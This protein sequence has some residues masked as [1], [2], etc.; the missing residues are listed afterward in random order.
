MKYKIDFVMRAPD[1]DQEHAV[2]RGYFVTASA[3]DLVVK[4]LRAVYSLPDC[5]VVV[6][7]FERVD[8]DS[9]SIAMTISDEVPE[10]VYLAVQIIVDHCKDRGLREVYGEE[11]PTDKK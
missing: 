2:Q 1:F 5:Y 11:V 7:T 4:T 8:N 3:D 10:T 9:I 6:D